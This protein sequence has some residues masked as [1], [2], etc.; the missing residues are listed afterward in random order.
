MEWIKNILDRFENFLKRAFLPSMVFYFF[1]ILFGM[2]DNKVLQDMKFVVEEKNFVWIFIVFSIGLSYFLNM[3]HQL[4]FDNNI[5]ENY[6]TKCLWTKENSVLGELREKVLEKIK[7]DE[8]FKESHLEENSDYI[9]YQR[10][11]SFLKNGKRYVDDTKTYGIVYL[12]FVGAMLILAFMTKKSLYW[13]LLGISVVIFFVIFEAI[14]AKYRS[15]AIRLY[16]N[17][18]QEKDGEKDEKDCDT[19]KLTLNCEKDKNA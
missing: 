3:L 15:R 14:K 9:L 10:I 8:K 6:E 19:L 5:K 4:L 7:N 18:L 1:V 17:Y 11:G 13:G 12:S 16:V 2:F